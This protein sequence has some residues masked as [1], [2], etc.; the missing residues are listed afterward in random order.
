MNRGDSMAVRFSSLSGQL[1]LT[2]NE[3]N[4]TGFET[5]IDRFNILAFVQIIAY[6]SR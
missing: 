1:V 5:G 4:V 6:F 3:L 2:S